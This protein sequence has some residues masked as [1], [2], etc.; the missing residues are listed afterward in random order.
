MSPEMA[1]PPAPR[2]EQSTA[3]VVPPSRRMRFPATAPRPAATTPRQCRGQRSSVATSASALFTAA[4]V[5]PAK[6]GCVQRASA[7]V[8]GRAL[9]RCG[10]GRRERPAARNQVKCGTTLA[11]GHLALE[12]ARATTYS[13]ALA[14]RPFAHSQAACQQPQARRTRARRHP[15]AML[16]RVAVPSCCPLSAPQCF[17]GVR[18][19]PPRR[20]RAAGSV[21]WVGR[22]APPQGSLVRRWR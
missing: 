9:A 10:G 6:A 1:W 14:A 11:I 18:L 8:H 4:C 21:A 15:C 16:A 2:S 22:S 12:R 5:H 20:P 19:Q 7:C 3:A 17:V 13:I